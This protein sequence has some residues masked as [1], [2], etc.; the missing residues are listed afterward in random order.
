[1]KRRFEKRA[2][3]RRSALG[4]RWFKRERDDAALHTQRFPRRWRALAR[5]HVTLVMTS[6]SQIVC[7]RPGGN[8]AR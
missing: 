7:E 6:Y 5:C 1:M 4:L 2:A 3:A 8:G